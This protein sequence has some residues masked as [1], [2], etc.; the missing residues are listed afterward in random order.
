MPAPDAAD[1]A[2]RDLLIDAAAAAGR[3]ARRHRSV[4]VDPVEKPDGQ[5]PVT[6]ADLEIDA[7]LREMLCAARPGYG[8]LSEESADG[9]ARL[10][11]R[12][13]FVVDPIDGTRAFAAGQPDYTHS[14]AVVDRGRPVAAAIHQP[15]RGRMWA[16]ARG[17]G[18]TRDGRAIAPSGR[19][20][21]DGATVLAAKPNLDARHWQGGPP[22][23]ERTFRSSLAYRL[24]LVAEG[25]F[26]AMVTLRPCWEWDIAAG[27]LI[28]LEAGAAVTDMAG[29]V[30]RFNNPH[31]QV[32]GTL[33]GTP[34]V[35][36]ALVDRLALAR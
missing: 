30:Q 2:D 1:V 16:A 27:A 10:D 4:G 25:R 35:Q 20:E 29:A 7:M 12:R 5:G 31:P 11:A 36:A 32:A 8:W 14:L 3:V 15:E 28:C 34:A 21:L 22:P 33:A 26:D 23:V 24:A 19:A 13:V 18:A 9:P 6:A 17:A